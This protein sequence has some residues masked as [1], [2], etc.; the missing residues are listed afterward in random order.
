[1]ILSIVGTSCYVYREPTDPLFRPNRSKSS[2]SPP[3]WY[4]AESRLLYNVMK[5]LNA[6]GYGLIKKRM[7]RDGH[8]FGAE[9]TQY[10]RSRDINGVPSLYIY[11]ANQATEVAA[12]S[13]N[14]LGR[15]GLNVMI[16]ADWADDRYFENQTREWVIRAEAQHPCYE[17]SWEAEATID[18]NEAFRRLYRGFRDLDEAR[19][20]LAT[21]PGD[22]CRLLDRSTGERLAAPCLRLIVPTSRSPSSRSKSLAGAVDLT[23]CFGLKEGLHPAGREGRQRP[24]DRACPEKITASCELHGHALTDVPVINPG[25]WW[26]KCVAYRGRR[27]VHAACSWSS[28]PITVTDAIDELSGQPAVRPPASRSAED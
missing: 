9:H 15:V 22:S 4:A 26:G 10:L 19:A 14:V 13:W 11:H 23:S 27:I 8:M 5:I 18:G 16:G 3:G 12:E 6:R 7:W 20:F 28:R 21:D 17:V 1:M 24:G 25:G 2:W